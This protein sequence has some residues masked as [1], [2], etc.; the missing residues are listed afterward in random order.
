MKQVQQKKHQQH[1]D[2]ELPQQKRQKKQKLT[3]AAEADTVVDRDDGAVVAI[4]KKPNK[5]TMSQRLISLN[6]RAVLSLWT[7]H[8]V[9]SCCLLTEAS[10]FLTT[11]RKNVQTKK[12]KKNDDGDDHQTPA[13]SH[14]SSPF[15]FTWVDMSSVYT[16]HEHL[17][18]QRVV[19]IDDDD[20][21]GGDVKK[22]DQ[23]D[24]DDDGDDLD[25][26]NGLC[27]AVVYN[28]ALTCHLM[29]CQAGESTEG[30]E[31]F[32]RAMGLYQ[33]LSYSVDFFDQVPACHRTTFLLGLWYNQGHIHSEFASHELTVRCFVHVQTLLIQLRVEQPALDMKETEL[34]LILLKPPSTAGAA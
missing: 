1:Q 16:S 20:G 22:D 29:A 5:T 24:S 11:I 4:V 25:R 9:D 27:W 12:K 10:S 21:G 17:M 7:G 28:L 3:A 6:N 26:A 15:P 23:A 30:R 19:L 33:M 34:N 8:V 32:A 31:H 14:S 2:L 13:P 18:I